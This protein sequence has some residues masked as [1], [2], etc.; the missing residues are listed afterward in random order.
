MELELVVDLIVFSASEKQVS[1]NIAKSKVARYVCFL[2]QI[3]EKHFMIVVIGISQTDSR[4][5]NDDFAL[6]KGRCRLVVTVKNTES[7]MRKCSS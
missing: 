3:F 4:T 5:I 7:A 6:V 2:T 1:I